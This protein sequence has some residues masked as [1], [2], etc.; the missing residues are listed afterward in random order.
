MKSGKTYSH[1]TI[2]ILKAMLGQLE[3]NDPAIAA[4]I[5]KE[6]GKSYEEKKQ[7]DLNKEIIRRLR[8]QNNKL[9]ER[10]DS[11]R[12]LLKQ[13]KINRNQ[14]LNR[15]ENLRKLNRSLSDALGSCRICWGE[16]VNCPHCKGNGVPGWRAINRPCYNKYVLAAIERVNNNTK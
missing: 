5:R 14:L 3:R 12:E 16:D 9:Q 4:V 7:Q 2:A 15:L 6:L 8:I 13:V 10:R 1:D 11:L